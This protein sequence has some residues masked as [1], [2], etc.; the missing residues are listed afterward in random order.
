MATLKNKI[1]KVHAAARVIVQ[2]YGH[3]KKFA[4]HMVAFAIKQI[5]N[6]TD[7]KLAEFLKKEPIGKMLRYT[8]KPNPST[9]II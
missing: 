1:V 8:N 5:E 4:K 2:R 6:L 3:R 9:L 7:E